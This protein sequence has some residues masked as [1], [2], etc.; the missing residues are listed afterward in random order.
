M[1]LHII[2]VKLITIIQLKTLQNGPAKVPVKEEATKVETRD[3]GEHLTT[4]TL[5]FTKVL[6]I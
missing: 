3:N 4:N 5:E 6:F 2:V 1:L